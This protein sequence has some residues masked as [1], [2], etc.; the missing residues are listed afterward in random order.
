MPGTSTL[1][2]RELRIERQLYVRI[3]EIWFHGRQLLLHSAASELHVQDEQ[4]V[5]GCGEVDVLLE[6]VFPDIRQV[7]TVI[8][9]KLLRNRRYDLERK[10]V[11]PIVDLL[12]RGSLVFEPIQ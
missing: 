5:V 3:L 2:N 8:T 7:I 10:L 12:I 6:H 11:G 1:V 9:F 4:H